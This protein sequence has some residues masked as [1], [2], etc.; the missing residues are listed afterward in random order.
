MIWDGLTSI[1]PVCVANKTPD[2]K[3]T[4]NI[5]IMGD[6]YST[7]ANY[8]P[9]GYATYYK[10]VM[11][12]FRPQVT[13]VNLTWWK[14]LAKEM[15]YKIVMN[16]SYSGST[17]CTTHYTTTP[18]DS[19]FVKRL[20]RYINNGFFKNNHI[21]TFFIFGGTNDD[22]NNSPLGM[23]QYE[24]FTDADLK[25]VF[26][27][28]CYTLSRLQEVCPKAKIVV[29][30]NTELDSAIGENF[31]IACQGFGAECIRLQNISKTASHPTVL[32][33]EQIATQIATH[34]R[35]NQ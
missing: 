30:V 2:V 23:L 1:E 32:G 10:E 6:S 13:N 8:I 27:A 33:M 15:G 4:E 21:D 25:K 3:K 9:A 17:I 18:L 22:W 14:L 24:N 34:L 28:F 16:D 26:P 20:D 29:I 7:F 31:A 12:S 5:F 11:D 19:C 35:A